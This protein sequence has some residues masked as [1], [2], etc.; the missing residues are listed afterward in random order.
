MGGRKTK[1]KT[2]KNPHKEG[3]STLLEEKGGTDKERG[4]KNRL[5]A[6]VT[7]GSSDYRSREELGMVRADD[8]QVAGGGGGKGERDDKMKIKRE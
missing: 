8:S 6:T 3:R 5:R 2:R 7:S 4:I 1:E